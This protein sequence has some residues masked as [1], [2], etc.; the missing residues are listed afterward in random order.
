MIKGY[1]LI[2]GRA[3]CLIEDF[4]ENIR[5]VWRDLIVKYPNSK[6]TFKV[7]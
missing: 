7:V 3:L 6:I 1:F 2:N 4:I 5:S